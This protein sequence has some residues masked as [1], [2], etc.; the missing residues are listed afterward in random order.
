MFISLF[1]KDWGRRELLISHPWALSTERVSKMKTKD[2]LAEKYTASSVLMGSFTC[3]SSML[4]V[5][6]SQCCH[7]GRNTINTEFR[8]LGIK[9]IL[10]DKAVCWF[11]CFKICEILMKTCLNELNTVSFRVVI[12]RSILPIVMFK[13]I[14]HTGHFWKGYFHSDSLF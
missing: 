13:D 2:Y 6:L 8:H 4:V 11:I 10:P 14:T 9:M 1:K 5:F 12:V 7:L 3:Q